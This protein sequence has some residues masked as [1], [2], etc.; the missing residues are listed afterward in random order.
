M[1]QLVVCPL[2]LRPVLVSVRLQPEHLVV[3]CIFRVNAPHIWSSSVTS[4]AP[5]SSAAGVTIRVVSI[6]ILVVS[7]MIA[8]TPCLLPPLCSCAIVVGYKDIQMSDGVHGLSQHSGLVEAKVIVIAKQVQCEK[9]QAH[10]QPLFEYGGGLAIAWQTPAHRGKRRRLP[11][12]TAACCSAVSF[13]CIPTAVSAARPPSPSL[14]AAYSGAVSFAYTHCSILQRSFLRL[15]P[16][17]SVSSAASFACAHRSMQQSSLLHPLLSPPHAWLDK[18]T[19]FW[20]ATCVLEA[21]GWACVAGQHC[22]MRAAGMERAR[23]AGHRQHLVHSAWMWSK[24]GLR[25]LEPAQARACKGLDVEQSR[26]SRLGTNF[27]RTWGRRGRGP[28]AS[29]GV[30]HPLP[31]PPRR[32]APGV[33]SG[34]EG[35]ALHLHR[36]L[37]KEVGAAVDQAA[38]GSSYPLPAAAAAGAPHAARLPSLL[39]GWR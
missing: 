31:G 37:L 1:G 7:T 12:L 15:H 11:T 16:H 25:V 28:G 14:T 17:R 23:L 2:D 21:L 18:G 13:A 30:P 4:R 38:P 10:A 27:F 36:P 39:R 6:I 29:P 9:P 34:R 5:C 26:P 3:L 33:V 35:G 24:V 8:I 20:E 22:G 32:L 19:S